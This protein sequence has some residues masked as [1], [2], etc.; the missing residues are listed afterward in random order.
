MRHIPTLGGGDT[1][2]F[3]EVVTNVGNVYDKNQ[4]FFTAPVNGLYSLSASIMSL[5]NAKLHCANLKNGMNVA[6]LY[7]GLNDYQADTATIVLELQASDRVWIKHLVGSG[8]ANQRVNVFYSYF[9]GFL[10]K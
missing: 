8:Y 10:T 4:G 2:I 7:G 6:N 5:L 1:L 3:D 9:S